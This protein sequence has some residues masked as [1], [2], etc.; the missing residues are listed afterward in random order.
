MPKIDPKKAFRI[1][2]IFLAALV[3]ISMVA[4]TV[5]PLLF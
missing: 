4:F 2:W 1:V 5:A 3:V